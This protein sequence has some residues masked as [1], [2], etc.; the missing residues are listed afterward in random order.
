MT[1]TPARKLKLKIACF[2]RKGLLAELLKAIESVNLSTREGTY[3]RRDPHMLV[4][5]ELEVSLNA[6]DD[7]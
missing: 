3:L 2:N 6:I 4:D 1:R 5:V 7:L